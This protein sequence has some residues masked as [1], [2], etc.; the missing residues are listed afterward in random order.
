MA[1][2]SEQNTPPSVNRYFYKNGR[3]IGRAPAGTMVFDS[4][5][6]H[7]HW[8]FEQFARYALLDGSKSLA[9]RSRKTGFCI[10]PT[11]AINLELP[12]APWNPYTGFFGACGDQ[13]SIWVRETLP[14]G[15]GDTYFQYLPGQSFDI[16]ALPNGTYY[17]EVQVNPLGLLYERNTKNDIQLRKVILS[18]TPGARGVRVPPWHGIDTEGQGCGPIC[19]QG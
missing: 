10:A 6:G 17:I 9:V 14:I 2:F 8:H 19:A 12:G 7:E 11:D 16:T 15:W 13:T 1:P 4:K 3:V 18:G 5:K